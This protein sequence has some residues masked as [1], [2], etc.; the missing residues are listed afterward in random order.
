MG[1]RGKSFLS[2][3]YS[4]VRIAKAYEGQ[5]NFDFRNVCRNMYEYHSL[6]ARYYDALGR[7]VEDACLL[8]EDSILSDLL[9]INFG[10][11]GE[12]IEDGDN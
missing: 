3:L 7:G 5:L 4:L 11:I 10:N 2:R 6:M 8:L 12:G 1:E 9:D